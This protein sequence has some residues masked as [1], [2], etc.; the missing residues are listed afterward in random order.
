[1]R[2]TYLGYQALQMPLPSSPFPSSSPHF[3]VGLLVQPSQ[4]Q[5]ESLSPPFLLSLSSLSP[6]KCIRSSP[7][8]ES[9]SPPFLLNVFGLHLK[10]Q[11]ATHCCPSLP[12]LLFL[13]SVLNARFLSTVAH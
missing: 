10:Q 3:V 1:M 12:P 5:P 7:A 8:A 9:L 2:P 11:P 13:H 6:H 4:T